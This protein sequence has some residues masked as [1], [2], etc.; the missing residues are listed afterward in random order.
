MTRSLAS[1]I[2]TPFRSVSSAQPVCLLRIATGITSP[3]VILYHDLPITGSIT[4]GGETYSPRPMDVPE[5][6]F[7]DTRE[8]GTISVRIGDAD[9][10]LAGYI[11]SGATFQY[12]RVRLQLTDR[13]VIDAAG[14]AVIRNDYFVE[15]YDRAEGFVTLNLAPLYGV[16]SLEVP[17]TT[18]TRSE[19]P[20]LP[21]SSLA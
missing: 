16:F 7:Q 20:G 1:A 15:S 14:S 6:R 10:T 2:T 4:F 8:N 13:S 12:V 21:P 3:S 17:I 5:Q 9:G 19:F 11:A 18:F